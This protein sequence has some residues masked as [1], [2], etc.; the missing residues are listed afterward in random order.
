MAR[1]TL[2]RAIGFGASFGLLALILWPFAPGSLLLWPFGL[3]AS[4]AGLSGLSIVAMTAIDWRY[5]RPRGARIRPLRGFDLFLGAGLVLLA[6][7]E[8]GDFRAAIG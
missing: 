7:L 6:I 4:L 8:L 1:W 2:R 5:H 3:V